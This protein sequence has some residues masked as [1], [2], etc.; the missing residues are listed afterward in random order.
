MHSRR[1]SCMN[2]DVCFQPLKV[3]GNIQDVQQTQTTWSSLKNSWFGSIHHSIG[4]GGAKKS[5]IKQNDNN[6]WS[7]GERFYNQVKRFVKECHHDSSS[8][9]CCN[10]MLFLG[11]WC[12]LCSRRNR[13]KHNWSLYSITTDRGMKFCLQ[14]WRYFHLFPWKTAGIYILKGTHYNG[15]W[16]TWNKINPPSVLRGMHG[17]NRSPTSILHG[18]CCF[19]IHIKFVFL[20]VS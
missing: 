15:T 14:G 6:L 1:G 16:L 4:L 3:R 20:G 17:D 9:H 2:T 11:N 8:M 5:R 12:V 18:V 10:I 19:C 7:Y 13:P